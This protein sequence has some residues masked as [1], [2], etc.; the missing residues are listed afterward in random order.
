MRS[1]KRILLLSVLT[2]FLSFN[3]YA[4]TSKDVNKQIRTAQSLYFKG[5]AQEANEAL[6]KAQEMAAEI[7]AGTDDAEKKKIE[8]IRR[9]DKQTSQRHR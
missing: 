4:V 5:K 9:T 6:E 1:L 8:S 3:V 2:L 7:M